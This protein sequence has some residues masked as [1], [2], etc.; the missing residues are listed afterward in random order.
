M[1]YIKDESATFL[2]WNFNANKTLILTWQSQRSHYANTLERTGGG[3]DNQYESI[4]CAEL[5]DVR[6]HSYD[7]ELTIYPSLSFL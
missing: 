6:I 5:Q 3:T 7:A 1:Y 2:T 4:I